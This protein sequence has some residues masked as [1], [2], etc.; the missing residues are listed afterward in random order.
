MDIV[1]IF[2]FDPSTESRVESADSLDF[3]ERGGIR[4]IAPLFIPDDVC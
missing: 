1:G 4:V 3:P 2:I